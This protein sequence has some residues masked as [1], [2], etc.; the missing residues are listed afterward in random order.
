M[1]LSGPPG[2][3]V[4][5]TQF[6]SFR[7]GRSRLNNRNPHQLKQR[8]LFFEAG[9]SNNNRIDKTVEGVIL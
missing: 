8:I 3:P 1:A 2:T 4:H 6:L 5:P 9:T 7:F